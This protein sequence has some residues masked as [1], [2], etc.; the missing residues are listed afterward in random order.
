MWYS[1]GRKVVPE[2]RMDLKIR[3]ATRED[4]P[5]LVPLIN[6]GSRGLAIYT[7]TARRSR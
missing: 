4:A 1:L 6:A 3:P 2:E 5:F 7:W